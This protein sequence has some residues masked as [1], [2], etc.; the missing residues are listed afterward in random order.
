MEATAA[1]ICIEKANDFVAHRWTAFEVSLQCCA[2]IYTAHQHTHTHTYAQ[3]IK[4]FTK[5][6]HNMRV[7]VS[8][9]RTPLERAAASD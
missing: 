1:S 8:I 9:F 2:V 7:C 3:P 5:C 4:K 6:S